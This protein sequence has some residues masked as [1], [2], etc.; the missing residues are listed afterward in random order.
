VTASIFNIGEGIPLTGTSTTYGNDA[1]GK[2]YRLTAE[3]GGSGPAHT[4][5]AQDMVY[6]LDTVALSPRREWCIISLKIAYAM[7][8]Y[9][10]TME[11][12]M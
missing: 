12:I 11:A 8:I 9:G 10:R 2:T 6:V 5:P 7:N 1:K 4:G 3:K